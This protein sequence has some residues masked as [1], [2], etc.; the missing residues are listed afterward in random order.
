MSELK[1][2]CRI[3]IIDGIT[4]LYYQEYDVVTD[5]DLI[6]VIVKGKSLNYVITHRKEGDV[7]SQEEFDLLTKEDA[8]RTII[9]LLEQMD[10]DLV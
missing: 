6:R 10:A 9:K 4:V 5:E 7:F 2:W 3:I 1:D 8:V